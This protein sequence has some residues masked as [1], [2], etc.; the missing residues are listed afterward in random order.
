M[1][2]GCGSG[3]AVGAR[4]GVA[5]GGSGVRVAVAVGDRVK[6]AAG[7]RAGSDVGAGWQ[8]ENRI[9]KKTTSK[10][11][12]FIASSLRIARLYLPNLKRK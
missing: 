11:G 6:A 5:V 1:L 9:P 4:V 12:H 2:I 3:V 7:G 8:A 10:S